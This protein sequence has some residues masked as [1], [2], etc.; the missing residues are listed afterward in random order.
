M[1][2]VASDAPTPDDFEVDHPGDYATSIPTTPPTGPRV[3]GSV[4]HV[5]HVSGFSP[6]SPSRW[7]LPLLL[8]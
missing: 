3:E 4:S 6:I 2:F 1:F 7:L 8:D 5:S